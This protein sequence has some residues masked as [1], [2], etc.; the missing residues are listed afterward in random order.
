MKYFWEPDTIGSYLC[1]TSAQISIFKYFPILEVYYVPVNFLKYTR[2]KSF[3]L[4]P[5]SVTL[6]SPDLPQLQSSKPKFDKEQWRIPGFDDPYYKYPYA[7]FG[8]GGA[9]LYLR[10][11]LC[12]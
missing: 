6:S 4:L 12:K 1:I 8:R 7:Q 2:V 11:K 5:I 9:E 3:N 10:S